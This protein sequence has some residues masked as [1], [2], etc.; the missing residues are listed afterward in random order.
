MSSIEVRPFHGRDR[1]Q[2]TDLVNSHAQAVVPG[3]GISVSALLSELERQPGEFIVDPWVS[4]RATL[5]AG[6]N[7]RVS[8]A[9]HL[10]RYYPDERAG[11][12]TAAPERSAGCCF[13]PRPRRGTRTGRTPRKPRRR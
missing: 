1:Q 7:G 3:L 12:R 9:A 11:Q 5:V 4:E 10:L 2:L 13:G 6:Q 8:A